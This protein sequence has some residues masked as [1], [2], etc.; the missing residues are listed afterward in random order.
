MTTAE[1]YSTDDVPPRQR[2]EW[3]RE[4]IGRE[5]ANV[6]IT[7]PKED[8]LFN[9]M[10]IYSAETLRLSSIR[11]NAIS[12]ERLPQEPTRDSHDAYFGVVLLSGEYLLE[13][14]GREAALRPGEMT[15]YDATKP[16][17]IFCP[18]TF[19]KLIV[20]IPR[21]I[22][23]ERFAGVERCTATRISGDAGIV[24]ATATF[25]R[26]FALHAD[27][28]S[29]HEFAAL[30]DQCAQLLTLTLASMHSETRISSR[31][32]SIALSRIKELVERRLR[33]PDM[34]AQIIARDAGLSSRYINDLFNDEGSSLMRYVLRRRLENCRRDLTSQAA[35]E[36]SIGEIAFRWGFNDLAHFSRTFKQAYGCSPSVYRAGR[37]G[38]RRFRR[39]A[40]I[41]N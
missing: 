41:S 36:L 34:S 37:R 6:E 26:S 20:S 28:L 14:D 19:S 16:H 15:I 38:R 29:A 23:K 1:I 17:R 27:A 7:P 32:R 33:N 39:V 35:A 24:G 3:L 2:E 9:E 31:S 8:R 40:L 10:T 11:S 5:Y 22:L 21:P 25:I 13:Q 18:G 12:L 30:S 4:V